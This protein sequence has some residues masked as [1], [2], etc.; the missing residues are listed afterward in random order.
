M[1]RWLA[2]FA[3]FAVMGAV[4]Y[5]FMAYR[6]DEREAQCRDR[7]A[8]KG[9]KTYVYTPPTGMGRRVGL[10]DCQCTR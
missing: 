2:G 7:C 10:D 1:S 4:I 3:A 8:A 9:S 6:V 5:V